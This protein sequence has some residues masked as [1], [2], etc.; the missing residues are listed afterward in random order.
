MSSFLSGDFPIQFPTSPSN[1]LPGSESS[2]R[3][4]S[5]ASNSDSD[6][7]SPSLRK[8]NCHTDRLAHLMC[9]HPLHRPTTGEAPYRMMVY[10]SSTLT[11]PLY[12]NGPWPA[13]VS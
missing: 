2:G 3:G 1:S 11:P 10:I 6:I 7:L 4:S 12:S 9:T 8:P 13:Q 5:N